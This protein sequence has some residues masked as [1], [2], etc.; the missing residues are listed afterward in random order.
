M[1]RSRLVLATLLLLSAMSPVVA[2]A[3][4]DDLPDLIA[5]PNGW[6][7]E[8]I[9]TDGKLLYAGSLADGALWRANPRT[10]ATEVLE[11]GAPGRVAD[12]VDYDRRRDLLWVAGGPTSE[13]RAHDAD[14]GDLVAT[15]TAP[16]ADSRFLNDLVVTRRAVFVTDSFNRELIVVPLGHGRRLPGPDAARTLPLTGDLVVQQGQF[17]LNGIVESHGMLLAVQ[18]ITGMLFA[19]DPGTGET[20]TVD[21]G[22]ELVT[23]GDGLELDHDVLYVVRNQNNEIAVVDLSRRLQSGEV[24]AHL[25]DA[26]FDIP[27]TAALLRHSLWAVNARFGTPPTPDT[28][29][30]VVRVDE[31]DD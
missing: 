12:G 1:T 27:T 17:N 9:T 13:I 25:Q 22:G 21:L 7:P 2:S 30:Q 18:S 10:G 29:Y 28:P 3:H 24:V 16:A 11:E 14:T 4:D 26:D 19:I 5:L 31:F 20:R 23:N 8:G 6:Q 15:Y